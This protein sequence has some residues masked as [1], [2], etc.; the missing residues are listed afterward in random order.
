MSYRIRSATPDDVAVLVAFTLREA[1]DAEGVALDPAAVWRGVDRAVR[2]PQLARYWVAEAPDGSAAASAS[3]TTEWSNFHGGHY[4]W[5]QSLF[6]D[7]AHRG[8][9]VV[10]RLL[11]HL[12]GAA[13][14]AG[15]L[16]L[17]LYAH[18]GNARARRVYERCAF[19]LAPYIL[20]RRSLSAG[21]VR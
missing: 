12:A 21:I 18:Q 1:R 15:A 7:D 14:D 9:G 4:W 17:R 13:T 16:D 19:T 3:I 5:V 2:D 20:M 6:V 8:R 10:D 11:D